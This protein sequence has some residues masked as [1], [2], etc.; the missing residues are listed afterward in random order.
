MMRCLRS[1]LLAIVVTLATVSV[2]SA[3][4]QWSEGDALLVVTTPSGASVPV[5]VTTYGF[6]LEHEAAVSAAQVSYTA[7]PLANRKTLVTVNDVVP[8]DSS[9]RSFVTRATV[10]TGPNATGTILNKTAGTSGRAMRLTF[11]VDQP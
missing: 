6:G 11:V 2:T 3:S 9:G 5:Y 8:N 1:V 10:S 7:V 4:S